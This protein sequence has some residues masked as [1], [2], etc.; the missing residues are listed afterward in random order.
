MPLRFTSELLI[1]RPVEAVWKAFDNPENLRAWQ[2]TLVS[3]TPVSGTPGQPG[4]VS[5]LTYHEGKRE[6][7]LIE[8][9][10]ARDYPERFS[11]AYDSGMGIS[12]IT[13]R[14][15]PHGGHGTRWEVECEF[16]FTGIWRLLGPLLG[17]MIRK[18]TVADLARF[19]DAV[20][21]GAIA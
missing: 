5:R 21:S 8:T 12:R 4:A 17:G 20:E 15:A 10:T 7:V 18:R 16:G 14:F 3:F 2:P 19:K 9:I 11:G 13:N 1:D 6:V